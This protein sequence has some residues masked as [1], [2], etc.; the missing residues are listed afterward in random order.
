METSTS[1]GAADNDGDVDADDLVVWHETYGDAAAIA[2]AASSLPGNVDFS[3]A[4]VAIWSADE[5][6]EASPALE[7]PPAVE[8]TLDLP[9]RDRAFSAIGSARRD[10]GEFVASHR[11]RPT[12]RGEWIVGWKDDAIE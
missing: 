12:V 5:D 3:V 1:T 2:S 9:A 7:E 10:S 6:R 4:A 8:G 11:A